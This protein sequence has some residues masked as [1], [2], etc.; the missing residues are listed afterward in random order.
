MK[1]PSLIL[2]AALLFVSVLLAQNVTKVTGPLAP[3]PAW[4]Y[5]RLTAADNGTYSQW[6]SGKIEVSQ[7]AFGNFVEALKI[8]G[9]LGKEVPADAG[10]GEVMNA[11]GA[12]HWELCSTDHPNPG[13]PVYHFK[14]PVQ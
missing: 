11:L 7:D 2:V 12:R 10:F 5:A 13:F 8:N 14:R 4:E 9:V 3:L 1:N 6:L